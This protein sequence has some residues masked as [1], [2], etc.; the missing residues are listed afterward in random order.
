MEKTKQWNSGFQD[1]KTC[2]PWNCLS[3]IKKIHSPLFH[4][5]L[6]YKASIFWY[7]ST[8]KQSMSYFKPSRCTNRC[9]LSTEKQNSTTA[10]LVDLST[11]GGNWVST[12]KVRGKD[13]GKAD[14]LNVHIYALKTKQNKLKVFHAMPTTWMWPLKKLK[15]WALTDIKQQKISWLPEHKG[16][17]KPNFLLKYYWKLKF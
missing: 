2:L 4:T 13:W 12:A 9:N 16:H 11:R 3:A 5:L 15:T 1:W 6:Q 7:F 10:I 8:Q 14:H 17:W